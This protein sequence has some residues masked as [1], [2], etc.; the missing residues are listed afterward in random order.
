TDPG[1]LLGTLRYMAPERFRGQADQRSDVFSLGLT[2]YEMATLR[3]AFAAPERAQLI[4]RMLHD[5]P[6]RPRAIDCRVPRDL[7]A[8]ILR[9]IA[10]EP[11]RR[12]QP[13]AALAEDLRRFLADRPIQ[14]KQSQWPEQF[15][16]WCRRNPALA[17]ATT[18][19][20]VLLLVTVAV[21]ATSNILIQRE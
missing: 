9:P 4:A 14:A 3:P 13:A 19:A 11:G 8:I 12:S 7:E 10:T 2:L 17:L 1:D 21:L 16:R 6:P 20:A 15:V 18:S 5:E